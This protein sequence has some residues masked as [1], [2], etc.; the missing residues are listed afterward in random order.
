VAVT[1]HQVDTII[2]QARRALEYLHPDNLP[3]RASIAWTLGYAHQLRG[4]R[5]AASQAYAEALASCQA[6]GHAVIAM[7]SRLGLG[8]VQESENQ[9]HLAA[10]TYRHTLKSAGDT[11]PPPIC[12][13]YLGLARICYQRN[14]LDAAE[15][16]VHE[17][18]P[19]ARQI[20]NTDRF[21]GCKVF[22][23]RLKLAQGDVSGAAAT[24]AEA[25]QLARQNNF[26]LQIPEVAAAQVLTL[27]RQ[28]KS[29]AAAQLAETHEL[30]ISRARAQLARGDA[31]AALPALEPLRRQAEAKGWEDK[32]LE[33]MVLQAVAH[34]AYGERDEAIQVLGGALALAEP[35]GYVRIF[36]DEGRPMVQLLS[37]AA[38]NGIMPGYIDELLA[39]FEAEKQKSEPGSHLS[40][41]QSPA[42][43]LSHRE[44]EV[45]RLI[46]QGLSN[47]EIS[48]Q[49]FLA[50]STVK[51][52]NRII[53]SKLMVERRTEAVARAREL[54]LL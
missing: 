15:R 18:L 33:V 22:L 31:S 45:L 46:A 16:H 9:L 39:A 49:L 3:V 32:R 34:H 29:G 24:L 52:H 40:P 53:F 13:A 14:D 54:G 44:L 50:L 27:L 37:E 19:L 8:G 35:E 42:E 23:S 47:R 41:V 7:M 30:P 21:V 48:Q 5:A 17:S 6:V 43:P 4:D 51:G 2:N 25:G 12:D 20:E 28:G 38:A 26:V 36:V 11:P 10:E 1:Q